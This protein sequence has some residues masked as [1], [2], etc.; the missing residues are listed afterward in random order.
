MNR[1]RRVRR[2]DRR[3]TIVVLTAFLM[4]F[5][6]AMLAF[7]IDIG[8]L[9]NAQTELQRS[10][11]SA[12]M[13][14]AWE[15]VDEDILLGLPYM[16]SAI[17]SARDRAEEYAG[18]NLVCTDSPGLDR[19]NANSADGDIV[20]GK[21]NYFDPNAQMTFGDATNYNAVKV[22]VRR[23]GAQNGVVPMFFARAIG[24]DG[25]AT[26]ADA[27]AAVIRQIRG[28]RAPADGSDLGMLPFALDEETWNAMLNGATS[29]NFAWDDV[30]EV[31][32][33]G[34]DGVR[35]MNLYPQGTGSPG[36]R[37]TVD[38]GSNNNSS[39]DIA[40]QITDGVSPSDL[41]HHGGKLELDENGELFLNGDTGISAGVKDE[42]LSIKGK[43]RIIP[44]FR[45]VV[46]PG[47]NATY[48]IVKFVGVRILEVKLTGGMN[49]KRVIIQP[50]NI[51]TDGVI[52]TTEQ[53][54]SYYIYSKPVLV[55]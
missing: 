30:D 39:N 10:A 49:S 43:P 9:V 54:T 22:R 12:A 14:A 37:G 24:V 52:P 4:I 36:N 19:N 53:D 2:K 35:E 23:T 31:V 34:G 17:S 46:D 29:D 13:A 48:T 21:L 18:M 50:A 55:R 7:A 51:V 42:L 15:M 6:M 27:T 11:D 1:R 33:H 26:E 45:E 25:A 40:R 38:V 41:E 16:T 47:N 44:I 3:G 20:I 8:Y 28:F 32:R 5:L